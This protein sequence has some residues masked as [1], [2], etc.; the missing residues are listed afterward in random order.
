MYVYVLCMYVCVN[1]CMYSVVCVCVYLCV[2]MHYAI[3]YICVYVTMCP[4]VSVL[5]DYTHTHTHT[6][7]HIYHRTILY[8][9][10][11]RI[12]SGQFRCQLHRVLVLAIF[13]N[14]YI[15]ED[16]GV[17]ELGVPSFERCLQPVTTHCPGVW[18]RQMYALF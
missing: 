18:S 7:T 16:S 12:S 5:A 2:S 11:L 15:P 8:S 3:C 1:V 14:F 10:A 6:H 4:C 9:P 13:D 17:P